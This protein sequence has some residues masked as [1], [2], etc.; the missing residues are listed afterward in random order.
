MAGIGADELA[1]L[2]GDLKDDLDAYLSAR[3][4]EGVR[5]VAEVVEFNRAHA[6]AELAHFG[7]EFLEAALES[8]GRQAE[9]VRRGQGPLPRLGRR[10]GA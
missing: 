7:Q 3:P 6:D 8:G 4:G 9:A 2:V 1:V 5:S 10:R